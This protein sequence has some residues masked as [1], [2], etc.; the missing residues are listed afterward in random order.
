MSATTLALLI[1]IAAAIFVVGVAAQQ[2]WTRR[3]GETPS[4][5]P[6]LNRRLN[7]VASVF[8]TL[9]A[10]VVSVD[11]ILLS[12][13]FNHYVDVTLPRDQAQDKC[14][15]QTIKVLEAWVQDQIARDRSVEMRDEANLAVL[16]RL[17][18]AQQPTMDELI[19]WRVA[20]AHD[21]EVREANQATEPSLPSCVP[22]A[23]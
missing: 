6:L 10:L 5:R 20:V 16:D 13:K 22:S 18:A 9:V 1:G 2:A 23:G 15:A 12:N 11:L 21:R 14:N 8:F 3:A 19:Q 17:I 4:A 7:V